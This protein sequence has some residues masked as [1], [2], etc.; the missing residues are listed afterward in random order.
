MYFI[1]DNLIGFVKRTHT[2]MCRF[3]K[4]ILLSLRVYRHPFV[5]SHKTW[6]MAYVYEI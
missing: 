1:L 3:K 4:N 5:N 6:F 2:V